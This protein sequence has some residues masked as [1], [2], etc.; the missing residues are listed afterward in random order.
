MFNISL[1]L[2]FAPLSVPL[3][4]L[5][6][7]YSSSSSDIWTAFCVRRESLSLA[8][9]SVFTACRRTPIKIHNYRQLSAVSPTTGLGRDVEPDLI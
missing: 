5:G 6:Q 4:L 2:V 8:T 1:I 3:Y 7:R 9:S